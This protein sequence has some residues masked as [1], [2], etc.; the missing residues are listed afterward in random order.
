MASDNCSDTY[1]SSRYVDNSFVLFNSRDHIVP[2][3]DYL[4]L[5]HP[6]IRFTFKIENDDQTLPFLDIS[7]KREF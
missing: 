4:N 7:I 3:L 1:F 2:L 5:K 6:N